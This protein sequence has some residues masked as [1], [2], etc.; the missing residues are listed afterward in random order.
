MISY[1]VGSTNN[2][3]VNTT[4]SYTCSIGYSI[5]GSNSKTCNADGEWIP[6]ELTI[7]KGQ[8]Q[9]V[10]KS[11]KFCLMKMILIPPIFQ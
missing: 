7:C 6:Q 9:V 4:A 10:P 11:C 5:S 2:R 1:S 3:P 8:F